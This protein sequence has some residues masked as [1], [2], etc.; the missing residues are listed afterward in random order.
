LMHHTLAL[1]SSYDTCHTLYDHMKPAQTCQYCRHCITHT[2]QLHTKW[3]KPGMSGPAKH[4][5]LTE[6]CLSRCI[7]CCSNLKYL[8][9]FFFKTYS[10]LYNNLND[11]WL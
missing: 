2:H 9:I 11:M 3:C 5:Q 7:Y 6:F 8:T 1:I 4:V 10:R